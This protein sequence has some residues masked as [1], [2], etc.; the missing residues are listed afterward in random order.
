MSVP[1]LPTPERAATA[2]AAHLKQP[3]SLHRLRPHRHHHPSH[4]CA[5][6]GAGQRQNLH[7]C[8]HTAASLAPRGRWPP[9]CPAPAPSQCSWI[10]LLPP[11]ATRACSAST[12]QCVPRLGPRRE[13]RSQHRARRCGT[14]PGPLAGPDRLREQWRRRVRG[15]TTCEKACPHCPLAT[16]A[17][18]THPDQCGEDGN[19]VDVF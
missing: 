8:G 10:A 15:R 12:G 7:N 19:L 4:L 18:L 6:L 1:W 14:G 2:L 17:C 13:A 9:C 11:C 16:E 5:V 3:S